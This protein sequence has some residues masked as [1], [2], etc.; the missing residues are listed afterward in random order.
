[1]Y[2]Q[3]YYSSGQKSSVSVFVRLQ[4]NL[5]YLKINTDNNR[6]VTVKNLGPVLQYQK[7]MPITAMAS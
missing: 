3:A 1:M 2:M 5:Y 7:K 4:S 6:R